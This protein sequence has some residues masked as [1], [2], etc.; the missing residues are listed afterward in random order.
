MPEVKVRAGFD[1]RHGKHNIPFFIVIFSFEMAG[2]RFHIVVYVHF[3]VRARIFPSQRHLYRLRTLREDVD[4]AEMCVLGICVCK[5][6]H[7][8]GQ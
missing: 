2:C 8:S 1:M 7:L 6:T 5:H 3:R 4:I